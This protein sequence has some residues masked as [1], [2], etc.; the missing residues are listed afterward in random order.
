[1]RQRD[2][3]S[4]R[5]RFAGERRDH[6][7]ARPRRRGPRI[8]ARQERPQIAV[9][10][11]PD[12]EDTRANEELALKLEKK[13]DTTI[14]GLAGQKRPLA[15]VMLTT[16]QR[17]HL[18]QRKVHRPGAKAL[19]A[20]PAVQAARK[21]ADARR[22]VGRV[23]PASASRLD[24]KTNKADKFYA[25]HQK[26]M[27]AGAVLGNPY[28]MP[29]GERSALQFFFI[30]VARSAGM[31]STRSFRTIRRRKAARSS[32]A[33]RRCGSSG[34]STAWP[35]APVPDGCTLLTMGIDCRKLVLHWVAGPGGR[36]APASRSITASI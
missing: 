34:K 1:V 22:S 2:S 29:R 31:P 4:A 27:D 25:K 26:A 23:R 18:R 16:I 5:A 36:M 3:L 32:R 35:A 21:A 6:R 19:V 33:S 12:T 9:I 20:R 10:D 28:R 13:I 24:D 30:E 8:E 14:A 15:R 11:D 17:R 7:H